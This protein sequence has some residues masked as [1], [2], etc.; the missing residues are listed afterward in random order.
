MQVPLKNNKEK[1]S[2]KFHP[3]SLV[4]NFFLSQAV[5][6]SS[7]DI[8]PGFRLKHPP[9]RKNRL[10]TGDKGIDYAVTWCS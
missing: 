8:L 2:R 3:S 5:M 10:S 7:G 9:L 4:F 1:V 6:T